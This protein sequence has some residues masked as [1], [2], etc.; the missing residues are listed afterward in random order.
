MLG[1]LLS[2]KLSYFSN[3]CSFIKGLYLQIFM[4]VL[5]LGLGL[6]FL[7][8]FLVFIPFIRWPGF[9]EGNNPD[10]NG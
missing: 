1:L 8:I 7:Y 4:Q 5:D 10:G 9:A 2:A 6:L 3:N